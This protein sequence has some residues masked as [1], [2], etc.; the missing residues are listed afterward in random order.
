MDV[1][2]VNAMNEE[3]KAKAL[4]NEREKS[5][6]IIAKLKEAIQ[7]YDVVSELN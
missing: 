1:S 2:L 7:Q 5:L 6:E 4:R 3:E